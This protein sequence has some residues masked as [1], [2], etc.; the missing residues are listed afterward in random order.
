MDHHHRQEP[1]KEIPNYPWDCVAAS[2]MSK[3]TYWTLVEPESMQV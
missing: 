3:F 1:E 2:E